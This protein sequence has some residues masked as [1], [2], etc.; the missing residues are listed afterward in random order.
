MYLF[1]LEFF[2]I[3][4]QEWDCWVIWQS[5]FSFLR[6]LHTGFHSGCN[7]YICSH[8]V[9]GL[10]FPHTLSNISYL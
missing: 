10:P 9:E 8:T 3:D 5:L 1:G 7:N 4:V 2:W 6:N